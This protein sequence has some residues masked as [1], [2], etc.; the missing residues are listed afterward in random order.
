MLT[1]EGK[2]ELKKFISGLIRTAS[3]EYTKFEAYTLETYGIKGKE[4]I[5]ELIQ[6]L[7]K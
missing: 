6:P 7:Q 1:N 2:F 4:I 5:L 3:G